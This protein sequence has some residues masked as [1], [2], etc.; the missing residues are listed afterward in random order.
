[1]PPV[2]IPPESL[3]M[4]RTFNSS[5]WYRIISL[6]TADPMVLQNIW[7]D[8]RILASVMNLARSH[9]FSNNSLIKYV[10]KVI[11]NYRGKFQAKF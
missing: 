6:D 2:E 4:L 7:N 11:M 10:L 3:G 1:M 8:H 9:G 5:F